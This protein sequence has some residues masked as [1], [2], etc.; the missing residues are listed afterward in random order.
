MDLIETGL[1]IVEESLAVG[2]TLLKF[3][4]SKGRVFF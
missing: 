1:V 3:P 2:E 4:A